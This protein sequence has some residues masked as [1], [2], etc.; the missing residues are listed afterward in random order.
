MHGKA[1]AL[2]WRTSA[3]LEEAIE[4]DTQRMSGE[5]G[6]EASGETA[7]AMRMVGLDVE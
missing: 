2:S 4:P 3:T 5:L 7:K 1:S 6:V